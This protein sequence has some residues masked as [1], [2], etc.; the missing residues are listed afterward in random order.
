MPETRIKSLSQGYKASKRPH[1]KEAGVF[2]AFPYHYLQS[3]TCSVCTGHCTGARNVMLNT[4][5]LCPIPLSQ[6]EGKGSKCTEY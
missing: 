4:A 5:H 6:K 3:S 2:P 1:E